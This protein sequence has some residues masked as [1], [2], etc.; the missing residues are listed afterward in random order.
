MIYIS[1]I[2]K[3]YNFIFTI[4]MI[5]GEN[6]NRDSI[7][8]NKL[9]IKNDENLAEGEFNEDE[10][11]Q[12]HEFIKSATSARI[13]FTSQISLKDWD[14]MSVD[15]LIALDK[16][17]FFRFYWNCI[18]LKHD[19]LRTFVYKTGL[20]PFFIRI[21]IFFTGIS[22]TFALNAIFYSDEYISQKNK[23]KLKTNYVN[24]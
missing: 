15:E 7:T 13:N 22:I 6:A 3:L 9:T 5:L 14:Y 16:R 19:I 11:E 17:S 24:I 2:I 1:F 21:I 4:I 20:N 8:N 10:Q 12:K 18:Y 23:F